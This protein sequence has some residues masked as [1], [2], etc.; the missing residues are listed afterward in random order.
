M[1]S[2]Q[3]VL[4]AMPLL[5]LTRDKALTESVIGV[6]CG[7]DASKGESA[8]LLRELKTSTR[9]ELPYSVRAAEVVGRF[10]RNQPPRPLVEVHAFLG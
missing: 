10:Y 1:Y 3:K 9:S 2:G 5:D 4:D 6:G 8:A 7:P